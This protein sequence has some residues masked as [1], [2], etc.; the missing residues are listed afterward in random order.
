MNTNFATELRHMTEQE[1]ALIGVTKLAYI[2]STPEGY[3]IHDADGT[4]IMVSE[5]LSLALDAI[6]Q[7]K[8]LQVTLH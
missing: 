2:R 1:L 4:V 3:V 8:M 5:T 6:E 7:T